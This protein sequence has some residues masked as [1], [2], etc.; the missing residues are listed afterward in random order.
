MEMKCNHPGAAMSSG[1]SD[2]GATWRCA[3]WQG[4]PQPPESCG[5]PFYICPHGMECPDVWE[6]AAH[7]PQCAQ[8][9]QSGD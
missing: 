2:G 3:M 1:Y 8:E 4:S 9:A 7:C 6:R 5:Q